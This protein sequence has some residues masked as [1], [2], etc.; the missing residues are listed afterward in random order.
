MNLHPKETTRNWLSYAVDFSA[1]QPTWHKEN[2]TGHGEYFRLH[3]G[4]DKPLA[5][6]LHGLGDRSVIPCKLLAKDLLK[7]GISCFILYSVFHSRRMPQE[8]RKK[9]PNLTPEEWFEGYQTS[10]TDVR[11]IVDW[12]SNREEINR[13][14]IAVIGISLGGSIAAIAMGTDNRISTGVFLVTGGNYENPAWVKKRRDSQQQVEYYEAQRHYAQYLADV[15]EKGFENV[16]PV[17]KSYLTD[18]MTFASNLRQR[19]IMMVNALW[20]ERIPRQATLDFWE[21]CGKPDIRWFPANHASIWLFYPFVRR[22]IIGFLKPT[23]EM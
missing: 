18:P 3:E 5:I 9:L 12:A 14:Q 4:H 22:E 15:A 1:S 16:I 23:F 2:T 10:V 17:K 7:R 19:S 11:Q 8:I 20:D 13:E 6:L 21:A